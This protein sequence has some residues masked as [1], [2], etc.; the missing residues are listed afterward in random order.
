MDPKTSQKGQSALILAAAYGK[1]D[2]VQVLL[3]GGAKIDLVDRGGSGLGGRGKGRGEWSLKDSNRF[4]R[5]GANALFTV[6][7]YVFCISYC[8][9]ELQSDCRR[10][11]TD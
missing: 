8:L 2:C 6:L 1:T 10:S 5:S 7:I 9:R 11:L 3:Q 4:S